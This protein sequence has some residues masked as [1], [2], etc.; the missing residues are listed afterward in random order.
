MIMG[1]DRSLR[2]RAWWGAVVVFA[3]G[4]ALVASSAASPPTVKQKEAEARSILAQVQALDQRSGAAI[5][6][7]DGARYELKQVKAQ[8]AHNKV[9][10]RWARHGYRI[11]EQRAEARLVA[12]FKSDDPSAI[13]AIL[14]A[15]NLN[16]MMDRIET[17]HATTALDRR[18][19]EQVKTKREVFERR[20]EALAALRQRKAQTLLQLTQRRREIEAQLAK[21]Q[22]LLASVQGEVQQ[23][24]IQEAERQARLIAA[25]RKRLA[26][27][28][29]ARAARAR[30]AA[31]A[32]ARAKAAAAAA[33]RTQTTTTATT[34]TTTNATT[35]IT[36]T[37]ATP[38]TTT[39]PTDPTDQPGRGQVTAPGHPQAASIA[40]QYLG[41]PYLWGGSSPTTGFDCS[42]LVMYVYGQLGIPLPH[43][44]GA[45]FGFGVPVPRDQLQ[46]G[47]LVFFDN[48]NHVGISLG[49]DEFVDAPHTG[50]VV[51]ISTISGWY[52]QNYVGARRI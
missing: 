16:D 35:T 24:K 27:E 21:R 36:S 46:P 33:A 28:Q 20:A 18:L 3:V 4:L 41:V 37:L 43:F 11:A 49:G 12:L 47:D 13:D 38:T 29:A 31:A 8:E 42:G 44:A 32:A 30:A 2:S 15:A 39:T 48:L 51:K 10:L 25:A 50:D 14:G 19:V 17:I 52:D 40:M 5:E 1:L 45:Q 6:A 7:W 22:Q 26:A 34:A 23:L 9:L